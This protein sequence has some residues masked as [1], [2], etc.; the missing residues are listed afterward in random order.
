MLLKISFFSFTTCFSSSHFFFFGC[1][2]YFGAFEQF[3]TLIFIYAYFP[4]V[5][6]TCEYFL[7]AL[8]VYA[9][10]VHWGLR[11]IFAQL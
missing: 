4:C 5:Y 8:L 3:A 9:F 1:P 6:V 11:E 2:T 10:V 7:F